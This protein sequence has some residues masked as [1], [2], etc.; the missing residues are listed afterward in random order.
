[1]K[2]DTLFLLTIVFTMV[3]SA[4]NGMQDPDP[5]L[6]ANLIK[7]RNTNLKRA[8]K[9]SLMT[10]GSLG[11]RMVLTKNSEESNLRP[12]VNAAAYAGAIYCASRAT[13]QLSEAAKMQYGL[14]T[15]H[16]GK[17]LTRN[18]AI[19]IEN[20]WDHS[21]LAV[22]HSIAAIG[23]AWAAK[24]TVE[25]SEVCAFAF[26]AASGSLA[27]SAIAHAIVASAFYNKK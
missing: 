25:S 15:M 12:L 9:N 10:L 27:H 22:K 20:I 16:S 24:K 8:A 26:A 19:R 1:M 17:R 21:W 5:E 14:R 13:N 23:C 4:M 6:V 7:D 3:T 18:Q 11:A 2:K